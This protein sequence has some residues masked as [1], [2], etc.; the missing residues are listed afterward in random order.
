MRPDNKVLFVIAMPEQRFRAVS[1][2][3]DALDLL[4]AGSHI[5]E[6]LWQTSFA[7]SLR[8]V[9]QYGHGRA[10][11]AGDAAH[12]HSPAGGRGMNLGIEDASVLAQRI[13]A[14]GLER[15]SEDRHA[16]GAQVV[17]ESDLQFRMTAIENPVL[18]CLR[19]AF[20]SHVAG[21]ERL[22]GPFRRRMAGLDHQAA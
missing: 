10:F 9:E 19:N 12:I 7:V 4:P 1:N 18:K 3:A 21:W 17:G 11:L 5:K 13:V 16:I 22:Q 2:H 6:I 8:Q 15:Y 14:G 20:L